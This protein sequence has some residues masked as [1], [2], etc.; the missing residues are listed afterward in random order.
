LLDLPC[1]RLFEV[2][3]FL[4]AQRRI[5][6]QALIGRDKYYHTGLIIGLCRIAVNSEPPLLP[7]F[8]AKADTENPKGALSFWAD[9]Y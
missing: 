7:R 1:G 9:L 4:S 5:D 2:I 3:E 6:H 8:T